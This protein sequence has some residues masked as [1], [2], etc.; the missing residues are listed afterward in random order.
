MQI[1]GDRDIPRYCSVR[2]IAPI[3]PYKAYLAGGTY[4]RFTPAQVGDLEAE[5]R[6][7]ESAFPLIA[8]RR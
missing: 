1:A 4:Y 6:P 3:L 7:V 2:S 8:V 5:I